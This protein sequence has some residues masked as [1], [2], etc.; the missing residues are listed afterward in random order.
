MRPGPEPDDG[1]HVTEP[2]P[3]HEEPVPAVQTTV[4]GK[5]VVRLSSVDLVSESGPSVVHMTGNAT[6]SAVRFPVATIAPA[7]RITWGAMTDPPGPEAAADFESLRTRLFGIAYQV[8]GRAA[9]A[10]DVVQDVWVRWQRADRAQVRDRVAFL[11]TITTRVALNAVT[12]AHARRE[13]SVGGWAPKH[14]LASLDPALEAE[15]GEAV[16]LAVQLLMERLS[17]VE[18]AVYVLREAFDYPFR[19]IAEVLELSEANARQLA[20]RARKH[21]AR[22]PHNPVDPAE[23]D[24]L[25]AAFLGAARAGDMARLVD[26]LA[27]RWKLVAI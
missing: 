1:G 10:E 2:G 19:E 15:R 13:V 6:T 17:P 16:E 27:G 24:E 8:L 7:R 11:V 18:R 21:L 12:S 25:F 3:E 14:D 23:R 20:R 5:I 26:Q 4:R 9:D 22:Q